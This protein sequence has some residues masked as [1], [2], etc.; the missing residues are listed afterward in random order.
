MN[1][2]NPTSKRYSTAFKL[3]VI[4]EVQ[5]GKSIEEVRRIYDIGG[6]ATVQR[7][8]KKFGKGN[9]T[10]KQERPMPA[11]ERSKIKQL[12]QEIELLE[13]TVA[14]LTVEKVCLESLIE[15][16]EKYYKID[17]KKNF[18]QVV[19]KEQKKKFQKPL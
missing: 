15:A 9:F 4:E 12:Q 7:W 17:I 8:L 11:K 16:V 13:A 2:E 14:K 19:L 1:I 18:G 10:R 5:A 6:H 3:K